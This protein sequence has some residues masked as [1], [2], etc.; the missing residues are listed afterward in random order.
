MPLRV[1]LRGLCDPG[2][3]TGSG[4]RE[5]AAVSGEYPFSRRCVWPLLCRAGLLPNC[6]PC[7]PPELASFWLLVVWNFGPKRALKARICTR[8]GAPRL[9]LVR[10]SRCG[11]ERIRRA[12]FE[13][14]FATPSARHGSISPAYVVHCSE[15]QGM[16]SAPLWQKTPESKV[17]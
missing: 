15:G 1:A 9:T 12:H 13:Y 6:L 7:F 2:H 11:P 17:G 4:S 8:S 14:L 10:S 16:W 3:Q 5:L